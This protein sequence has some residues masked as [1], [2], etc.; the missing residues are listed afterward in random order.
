[1][2]CANGGRKMALIIGLTGGIAS[3]KSTIAKMFMEAGIPVVDADIVAR[4]VV[5]VGQ[6]AYHKIIQS[7]GEEILQEDNTINRKKL[8]SIIFHQ[9]EKRLLLNS[10]V[11][12]AV[13]QSIENKK[14]KYIKEGHEIV[15]LDIP[16]LLESEERYGIDKILTV[17][18]DK[19]TQLTRLMNRNQLSEAEAKARIASQMPLGEKVQLADEYIDNSGT[20]EESKEQLIQILNRWGK[21]GMMK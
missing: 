9:E 16:L 8:G 5:E 17:Y 18:V 15:V 3:G 6:P 1:M 11:H 7:F 19:E 2:T 13:Q 10:I 12:P 4:E 14:E 20:V 21:E